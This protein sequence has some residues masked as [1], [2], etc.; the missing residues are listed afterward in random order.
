VKIA[1]ALGLVLVAG[2]VP[3]V[4]CGQTPVTVPLR[5]LE[6]SGKVAFVCVE[7]ARTLPVD[8]SGEPGPPRTQPMT[9]CRYLAPTVPDRT[10]YGYPHAIALVTQTVRGEVAVVDVTANTVLDADPSTPGFGFLPVGTAPTDIVATTGGT[11]S[12]VSVADPIRPGIFALPTSLVLPFDVTGSK[13]GPPRLTS[14]PACALPAAPGTMVIVSDRADEAHCPGGDLAGAGPAAPSP[15]SDLSAEVP[16]FGRA[17]LVVT[18]PELGSLAVIDAQD[19]L[20]RPPGSFDACPIEQIRKLAYE[21]GVLAP[22]AA[23]AG[24]AAGDA[25][26][27]A[28]PEPALAMPTASPH[29]AQMAYADDGRL[30]VT[31][32]RAPV[33]HVLDATSPCSLQELPPLL[34][35]SADDPSR[36]V[37]SDAIAV[38]PLT[39]DE[40]RYVY[41]VDLKD[42][43]Q[44]SLMVFDV[45]AGS[46]VRTPLLRPDAIKAPFE[47][48]DR[49][50]FQAP[51]Q[52]ITF[53]RHDSPIINGDDASGVTQAI[54]CDPEDPN[55]P[56]RAP[57]DFLSS[58]A[59][60]R[61]LRGL[62]GFAML[63]DGNI[64]VLDVDDLDG[65]CRRPKASDSVFLG[66]PG[67]RPDVTDPS[68]TPPFPAATDES[69]C[70][71]V[72][73]HHKR[74]APYII[75][76][77]AVGNHSPALQTLPI[78]HDKDGTTISGEGVNRPKLLG[79]LLVT[80]GSNG[81]TIAASDI[82]KKY[83]S[84][85]IGG[86]VDSTKLSPYPY[87][88][89]Q[90]V[91][92]A[93]ASNVEGGVAEAGAVEAG[94]VEAGSA[95][96][97]AGAEAGA[98]S[99]AATQD[100]VAF[101]LT[102]PRAHR[103][104]GW[105]VTFEGS[106]PGFGGH[107]GRLSCPAGNDCI[108]GTGKGYVFTDPNA[109]FCGSGVHDA[110]LAA[111]SRIG[112]ADIMS[113]VEPLP[114]PED[115]Y[116][117]SPTTT[118]DHV[119]C[120]AAFGTPDNPSPAGLRDLEILEAYQD[121]LQLR[122]KRIP[123]PAHPET[124][125]LSL[126]CCFPY[127]VT[128][129][130]R[131][132]N[133]WIVQGS[134]LPFE[135]H[136]ITDPASSDPATARCVES[137]D[138]RLALRNGRARMFAYGEPV[139]TFD[140][141]RLFRNAVMRFAVWAPAP[142]TP[143]CTTCLRR[144]MAFAFTEVGGFVPL[145][146][147]VATNALVS[148]QSIEFIPGLEQLAVPDAISQG[149][150]LV[151]LSRLAPVQSFY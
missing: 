73:R 76:S 97:D 65:R 30:F 12:F 15:G 115:P 137:C 32:D 11:A 8:D 66:C 91:T 146:V 80:K 53:A 38:S 94:A 52:S 124:D 100:W 7:D 79:P 129:T 84:A 5:S 101:D 39:S 113:I 134:Q 6:R 31:D 22:A 54:P 48:S 96:S 116:W 36:V 55:S 147:P 47:P 104:R 27:C 35:V 128:Y 70:N 19:L 50:T 127:Q 150:I 132:A 77:N 49:I 99:Q 34:A 45:S 21:P 63:R 126:T 106:L 108:G 110:A 98:V 75:N 2:I 59:G 114:D 81:E 143:P 56:Y 13:K 29:P 14:F 119:R 40:K 28:Q 148:P 1:R 62:F 92:D 121:R 16:V 139:P 88:S 61:N 26:V 120:E 71:V 133:Q 44:G 117:S 130:I 4:G 103:D 105:G 51:V 60:P 82:V 93:G 57:T 138:P 9:H 67:K 95:M 144:D 33:I 145:F 23:D 142:E 123:D 69:S 3:W 102:E 37:S 136:V 46:Q 41:A 90:A 83:I 25:G 64:A 135:H 72:E 42:S 58:G 24:A 87:G 68:A 18:L 20:A 125:N 43:Y 141:P 107:L 111:E 118:C 122:S 112:T 85:I 86:S 78:F 74:S 17:K 140:D 10:N 149:L 109:A 89:Q 151:D 131:G